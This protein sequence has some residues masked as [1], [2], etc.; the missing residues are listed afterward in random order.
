MKIRS[1]F[2]HHKDIPVNNTCL[3]DNVNPVIHIS[4][5]PKAAKSLVLI[6]EDVDAAP[7][8]W[9]HWLLF[10]IP[11]TT[12]QIKEGSI[13]EG[14]LKVLPTITRMVMKDLVQNILKAPTTIGLGFTP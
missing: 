11:V 8:P 6:F 9:T 5:V 1:T 4:E 14:Q 7:R 2:E 10:N 13:P 12:Y 3:G